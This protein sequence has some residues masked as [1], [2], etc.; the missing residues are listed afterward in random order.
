ML[1]LA[2]EIIQLLKK[3]FSDPDRRHTAQTEYCKLYQGKNTFTTFWAEFQRLTVELDYSK[4]TLLNDLQFKINQGMQKALVAKVR[5]TTL[6][7][8]AKKCML[9]DQNLQR[10][11][12]KEKRIKLQT[13]TPQKPSGQS[14]PAPTTTEAIAP[15]KKLYCLPHQDP[16]KESLIKLGK[17]FHCY[18]SSHCA[19]NCP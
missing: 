14:L 2:E 5:T 16:E 3:V 15:Q 10:I 19:C 8:F 11:Y 6:H 4:E 13:L 17:C 7:K 1:K 18:K 12:K 9:V